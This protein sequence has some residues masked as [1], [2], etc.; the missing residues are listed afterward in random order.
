VKDNEWLT[1]FCL[2]F[3]NMAGQVSNM[4]GQ[5]LIQPTVSLRKNTKLAW[6]FFKSFIKEVMV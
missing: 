5:K 6:K 4:Q 2:S 3:V 1:K